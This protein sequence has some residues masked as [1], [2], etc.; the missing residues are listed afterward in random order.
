MDVMLVSGCWGSPVAFSSLLV[1]VQRYRLMI[2]PIA[3]AR[4]LLRVSSR[5]REMPTATACFLGNFPVL[6]SSA[7]YFP[8]SSRVFP[9]S[10][11]YLVLFTSSSSLVSLATVAGARHRS[12]D[13][14]T[15][16]G[17]AGARLASPDDRGRSPWR[18]SRRPRRPG[19]RVPGR[20]PRGSRPR[21]GLRGDLLILP[22]RFPVPGGP[23]GAPRGAGRLLARPRDP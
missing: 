9:L 18:R 10:F 17:R 2:S 16:V 14:V 15:G 19:P 22:P 12:W 1:G 21:V 5:A 7:T 20:Q 4:L 13:S 8:A 23:P 3:L 6:I 11:G